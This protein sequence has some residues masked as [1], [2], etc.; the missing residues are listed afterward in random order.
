MA[1]PAGTRLGPTL[2][3]VKV[4]T[5]GDGLAMGA[6]RPLFV[7]NADP[8]TVLRNVYSPPTD[9]QRFLLM[10]PL[11]PG[12]TSPLVGVLNWTAGLTQK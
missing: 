6:P 3:A 9:G 7:T 5:R 12:G 11:V 1:L 4:Q 10:S 2:M 8:A